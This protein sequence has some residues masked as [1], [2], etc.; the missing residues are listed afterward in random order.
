MRTA[1]IRPQVGGIIKSRLFTQGSEVK[2]GQPLFQID[3]APFEVDVEIAS[4]SLKRAEASYRQLR[5]RTDRLAQ[6]Q[7]SGAVS[8]QDYDDA[9]ENTAQAAASVAE[10]TAS[11]NRKNSTSLIQPSNRPLMAGSS[12]NS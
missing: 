4:A 5:Q 6:L 9:K 11:L 1:E 7:N 12:K 3:R 10:A 2:A 8:R